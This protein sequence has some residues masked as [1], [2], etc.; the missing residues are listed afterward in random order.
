MDM[1]FGSINVGKLGQDGF[2]GGSSSPRMQPSSINN[3][4]A[5]PQA[6]QL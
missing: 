3:N 5:N 1:G 2:G 6:Q 4:A